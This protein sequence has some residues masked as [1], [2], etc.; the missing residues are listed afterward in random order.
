[1]IPNKS[2]HYASTI[3]Q[4]A[5]FL[6]PNRGLGARRGLLKRFDFFDPKSGQTKFR[7]GL[8]LKR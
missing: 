6:A 3:T 1:M 7:Q 5:P 2:E 4:L 8:A